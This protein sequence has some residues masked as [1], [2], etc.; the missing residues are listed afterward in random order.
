MAGKGIL[1]TMEE[2]ILLLQRQNE[3]LQAQV[4]L[5]ATACGFDIRTQIDSNQPLDHTVLGLVQ[6]GDYFFRPEDAPAIKP[7]TTKATTDKLASMEL[8]G[9]DLEMDD[10]EVD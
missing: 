3:A 2:R 8:S 5:L 6:R 9:S 10:L 4:Y 7:T 1:E